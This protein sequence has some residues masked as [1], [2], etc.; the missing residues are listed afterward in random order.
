MSRR[1]QRMRRYRPGRPLPAVPLPA[2]AE[3]PFSPT[4]ASPGGL[5]LDLRPRG[6]EA[7]LSLPRR[8]QALA[9]VVGDEPH[10]FTGL[11]SCAVARVK[12]AD[13]AAALGHLKALPETRSLPLIVVGAGA[14][15]P[16]ALALTARLGPAAD[17]LILDREV[18]SPV[19][20]TPTRSGRGDCR[21]FVGKCTGAGRPR[22][23]HAQRRRL[24]RSIERELRREHRA[25]GCRGSKE[26]HRGAARRNSAIARDRRGQGERACQER[27][28]GG[29]EFEQADVAT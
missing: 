22:L 23:A 10:G 18:D 5:E 9:L 20:L 3:L 24:S 19:V 11:E 21:E 13:L 29:D 16:V 26:Q 25:R 28:A 6:V 17:G 2:L 27:R 14:D 15:A 12:R 7:T 8:P 4:T 1:Q